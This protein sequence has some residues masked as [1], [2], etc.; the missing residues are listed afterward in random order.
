MWHPSCRKVVLSKLLLSNARLINDGEIRDMDVLID[1][2]RIAKVATSIAAPESARVLDLDGAW[3]MPGMIDDQVHFREPGLTHKGDL[4]SES[5]A[6][7]AGGITSFIDMPNVNPQTTTRAA[8]QDKYGIAKNRCAANYGF[9]L[10]ATNS[11]I[12]EIKALKVGE[13]AGIKAFLGASTG[14]MLVDNPEALDKLF[15]HAPVIVLTH[16]EDSPMIW[17]AEAAARAKYGD[18]VPFREHPAIRS[19]EACLKSSTMASGLA[20]K[21]DALLHILHLTTAVEMALF[22][23][24]H[25]SQKRITAEVCVHHLWFDESRYDELGAKIKCNP[26]IKRKEDREALIAALND[27]RIDVIATD[28]AP[29]TASEKSGSYFHAPAGLPLVQHALLTLFDLALEGKFSL[30]LVV[31]RACHAPADLFGI[32][33][34]GYVREGYYADLVVVDPTRPYRVEASGLLSKCRWS[35]FEGH[36][37]KSSIDT[38]IINGQ[39]VYQNGALSGAVVGKKLEFGRAR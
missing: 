3:L 10:G 6:A 29:H 26:S 34:R 12:D 8:L 1:G 39:V 23:G 9:Y 22:S 7:A 37:F 17:A 32:A 18:D 33:E 11:N 25:R 38:T 5:A 16:C 19:A 28:H 27:Q 31:D 4:A 36:E 2:E 24:A 13:A 30:E 20:R 15:E 35:P 21:H 14:D